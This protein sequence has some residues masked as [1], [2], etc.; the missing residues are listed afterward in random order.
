MWGGLLARIGLFTYIV[1]L[2]KPNGQPRSQQA[3]F[4][5]SHG[6]NIARPVLAV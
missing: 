6:E 4:I 2:L 3:L 1:F 5:G